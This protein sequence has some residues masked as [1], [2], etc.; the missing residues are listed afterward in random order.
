MSFALSNVVLETK[1]TCKKCNL[2]ESKYF[3]LPVCEE[4]NSL[5]HKANNHEGCSNK[6]LRFLKG[7]WD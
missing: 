3:S 7:E 6:L 1:E 4:C 5:F 2:K